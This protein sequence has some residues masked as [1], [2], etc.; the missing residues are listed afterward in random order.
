MSFGSIDLL[1]NIVVMLFWIRLWNRNSRLV[2]FNPYLSGIEHVTE[3]VI[4]LFKPLVK[5]RAE[6]VAAVSC[7]LILI[8]FRA[9]ALPGVNLQGIQNAWQI[10]LG[11][12]GIT[13]SSCALSQVP[14]FLLFSILSFAVFLFQ[15][16]VFA[17]LFL[18]GYQQGMPS[19]RMTEFLYAISRPFSDTRPRQRPWFLLAYG[20]LVIMLINFTAHGSVANTPVSGAALI[21]VPARY[22]VA[23]IAGAV[24]LL[25]VLRSLLF[26]L[27]IGSWILM[28][29]GSN[30]FMIICQEW[31][32]FLL[33][34][35]R[36]FPLRV[37]PLDLTPIIAFFALG[38][39]HW[40]TKNILTRLYV[41][42]LMI[43]A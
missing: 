41:Y 24:D 21:L 29:I 16:W 19:D 14:L 25:M 7:L 6:T 11:F 37:G 23:T 34:P 12:V 20:I 31:L 17:V 26:I 43:S 42:L 10:Q 27:I 22:A 3:P 36:R 8:L 33:S 39:I 15:V 40:V 30:T 18:K 32:N 13:P 1:F 5:N 9:L 38:I 2:Q 28:F 35:F 4:A